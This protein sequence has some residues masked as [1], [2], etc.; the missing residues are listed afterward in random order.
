MRKHRLFLAVLAGLLVLGTLF[1]GAVSAQRPTTPT[2]DE[3]DD[4]V[5]VPGAGVL[6]HWFGRAMGRSFG[7]GVKVGRHLG[8]TD[9]MV[10]AVAEV[11][12]LGAE[13]VRQALADGQSLSDIITEN[14]ATVEEAVDAFIA[15]RVAALQ[16]ARDE[17]IERVQQGFPGAR[18]AMAPLGGG[19]LLDVIVDLTSYES[20]ADIQAAL[21]DGMTVE[22]VITEGGS[23]VDDVVTEYLDRRQAALDELVA[24]ERITQEQADAM[25]E[26]IE[27]QVRERIEEGLG[28]WPGGFAPG[29]PRGGMFGPR[30]G[31][32]GTAS[33]QGTGFQRGARTNGSSI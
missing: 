26:R 27:E 1:V 32:K 25:F 18:G 4:G 29:H 23:T 17:M 2:P 5:D 6:G 13:E 10:D 22:E 31:G 11:T 3:E 28:A 16:D 8:G 30:A 19:T 12:G 14:G 9:A 15:N 21:A 24:D 33:Q 7:L 20:A